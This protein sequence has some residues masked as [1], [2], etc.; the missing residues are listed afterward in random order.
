MEE[1]AQDPQSQTSMVG[2][3]FFNTPPCLTIL[4]SD[5]WREGLDRIA[6]MAQFSLIL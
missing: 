4:F 3:L 5:T 6:Q 2:I 1:P